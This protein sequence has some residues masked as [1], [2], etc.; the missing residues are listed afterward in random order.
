MKNLSYIFSI[1]LIV[2]LLFS[3]CEF[4]N[5]EAPQIVF[6][7]VLK[8]GDKS[9][10]T[11]HAV[12]FR[13]YQYKE[14]GFVSA[15]SGWIDVWM[16]ELGEFNAKLFPGRYKM[17][18]NTEGGVNYIHK[19]TNFPTQVLNDG[20][21]ALDT[22]KFTLSSNG[23]MTLTGKPLTDNPNLEFNA[24][25]FNLDVTPFYDVRNFTAIFRNDSIVSSFSIKK[26]STRTDNLVLF[27]NVTLFVSPTIFVNNATQL[28]VAASPAPKIVTG[29]DFVQV[30]L[31]CSLKD[32]YSN[33]YYISNYR[34]YAYCRIGI[35]L[36][37]SGQEFN[38]SD[39]IKVSDIPQET[40]EK[41]K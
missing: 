16:N 4:D 22:I 38:F 26:L 33:T 11:T 27:R 28:N 12:L 36:R 2:S 6:H 8:N 30:T 35:A 1:L 18:V 15:G 25:D 34:N 40:I 24:S 20:T 7:G 32:Y 5:Y 37:L 3:S 39:V 41:F 13:L 21:T 14:D 10:N 23:K 9:V 17:V 29:T 31:K 19:W